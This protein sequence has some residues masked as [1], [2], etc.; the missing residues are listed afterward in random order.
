VGLLTGRRFFA[1]H[2]A[3]DVGK[4]LGQFEFA[5]KVLRLEVLEERLAILGDVDVELLE[6]GDGVELAYVQHRQ[7]LHGRVHF[8][9]GDLRRVGHVVVE[10]R[11]HFAESIHEDKKINN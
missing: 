7:L 3:G 4:S 1:L 5:A 9:V 11:H 10:A 2:D 6:R 8:L